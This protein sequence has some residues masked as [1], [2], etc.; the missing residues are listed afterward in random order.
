MWMKCNG[1]AVRASGLAAISAKVL[2]ISLAAGG[3][4]D[5]RL[6]RLRQPQAVPIAEMERSEAQGIASCVGETG[7][8]RLLIA[9]ADCV[10]LR[11][12]R[13]SAPM[14]ARARRIVEQE[15]YRAR[16]A[17]ACLRAPR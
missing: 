2:G 17:D 7:D 10:V 3:I 15:L 11:S 14:G 5:P 12:F 4:C 1:V 6:R 8:V 9:E 16:V 13:E